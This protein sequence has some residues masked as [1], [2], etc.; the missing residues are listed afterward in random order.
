MSVKLKEG[1]GQNSIWVP[2][3]TLATTR[4]TTVPWWPI[5]LEMCQNRCCKIASA[6]SPGQVT[7][8]WPPFSIESIVDPDFSS[9][10]SFATKVFPFL[11]V[12]GRAW[13]L[14]S[15]GL[16]CFQIHMLMFFERERTA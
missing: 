10:E 1:K 2:R 4:A 11:F 15:W 14:K 13:L 12:C 8:Y 6:D 16:Y 7:S 5:L 9:G 3:G